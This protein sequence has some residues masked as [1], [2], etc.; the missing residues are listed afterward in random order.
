MVTC[1]RLLKAGGSETCCIGASRSE[2]GL[3]VKVEITC[4]EDDFLV[5]VTRIVH[6]VAALATELAATMAQPV[7]NDER[8]KDLTGA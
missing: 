6:V 5:P 1:W 8:V 4:C 3:Y 2:A 7:Q